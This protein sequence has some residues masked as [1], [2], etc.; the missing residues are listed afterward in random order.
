MIWL[1]NLKDISILVVF[2]ITVFSVIYTVFSV[3]CNMGCKGG[4]AI[5]QS[6]I[7]TSNPLGP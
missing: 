5:Y 6:P 1:I 4:V 7:A 2:L 3:T